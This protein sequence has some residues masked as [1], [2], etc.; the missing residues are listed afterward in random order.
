MPEEMHSLLTIFQGWDGYQI[1]LVRAI[2]PLSREQ[3]LYRPAVQHLTYAQQV[4]SRIISVKD[5]S[6][7]S[8]VPSV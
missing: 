6:T 1:S 3:L 7:G 8:S 4:N 2:V 5:V